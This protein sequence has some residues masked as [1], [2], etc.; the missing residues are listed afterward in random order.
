M[1]CV[2]QPIISVDVV[3]I[4]KEL[5]FY[6]FYYFDNQR[7]YIQVCKNIFFQIRRLI[8]RITTFRHISPL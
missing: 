2:S 7:N 4:I 5:I 1:G 3:L 6:K 8:F